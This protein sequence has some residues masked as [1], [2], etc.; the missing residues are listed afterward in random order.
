MNVRGATKADFDRIVE[1]IDHWWGGPI[2][3]FAHPVF[4]YELGEGALVVEQ[5]SDIIGF[6]FGFVVPGVDGEPRTGD[7]AVR[8]GYVHL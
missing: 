6:L 4:F 5:G 1:V 3:T 7:G 8:T 2:G